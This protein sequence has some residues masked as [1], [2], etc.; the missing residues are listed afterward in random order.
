MKWNRDTT[1]LAK[2]YGAVIVLLAT[3]AVLAGGV[4]FER[5]GR[6]PLSNAFAP[7]DP[8]TLK[9]LKLL[10]DA[11]TNK[12]PPIPKGT[13]SRN[14]PKQA[15]V[16][17]PPPSQVLLTWDAVDPLYYY[18]VMINTTPTATNQTWR[19]L[20]AVI[21]N[22]CTVD[23]TGVPYAEFSVISVDSNGVQSHYFP[24]NH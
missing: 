5:L 19:A 2:A 20:G 21:T 13:V 9:V 10:A 11:R 6:A 1:D 12:P 15:V 4:S 22:T 18:I 14:V 8:Q 17:P 3:L 24:V 7:L 23:M 16:A